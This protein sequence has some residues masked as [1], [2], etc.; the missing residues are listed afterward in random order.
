MS[1]NSRLSLAA[2]LR[3]D[4]NDAA[5]GGREEQRGGE[6]QTVVMDLLLML[7]E[8]VLKLPG[9]GSKPAGPF[10]FCLCSFC[11]FICVYYLSVAF[12]L[13]HSF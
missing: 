12:L 2:G 9:P 13:I 1:D 4:V 11:L 5:E 7:T 3:H 6:V 10:L 8:L